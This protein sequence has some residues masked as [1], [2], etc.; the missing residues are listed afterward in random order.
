MG[1]PV[2]LS[3]P[4]GARYQAAPH[5]ENSYRLATSDAGC[6]SVGG[7][8][9]CPAGAHEEV[10]LCDLKGGGQRGNH[11]FTRSTLRPERSALPGCAT[12]RELVQVSDVGRG[13]RIGGRSRA[14]PGGSPRR[15]GTL[16]SERRGSTGEP[17]VHPFYSPTRTERAT[18]LRHT[19]RTRTG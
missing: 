5:P 11:G 7:A 3:D 10:G 8:G 9:L 14:L 2:L 19:P 1:S 13:V 4:N 12:P 15:G 18:R 6:G 17:W 16:R